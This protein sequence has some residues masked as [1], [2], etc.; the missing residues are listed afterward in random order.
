MT[1]RLIDGLGNRAVGTLPDGDRY[2]GGI[3]RGIEVVDEAGKVIGRAPY[4][5]V[6]D[7]EWDRAEQERINSKY[8]RRNPGEPR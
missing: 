3:V 4:R 1:E 5:W 7:E 2:L 8:L 6:P